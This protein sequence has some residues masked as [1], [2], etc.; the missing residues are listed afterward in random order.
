MFTSY[1][2]NR[3][4]VTARQQGLRHEARHHHLVRL[5][6]MGRRARRAQPAAPAARPLPP[7]ALPL[8]AAL[9]V[10]AWHEDHRAA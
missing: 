10:K 4:L 2:I 3:A 8:P 9:A 1:E 5:A 7:Q 6:R